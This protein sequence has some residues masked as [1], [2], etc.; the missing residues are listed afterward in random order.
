M[1]KYNQYSISK[2]KNLI[3]QGAEAANDY[4][5]I[6]DLLYSHDYTLSEFELV[7]IGFQNPNFVPGEVIVSNLYFLE[8]LM[9]TSKLKAFIKL[10][11]LNSLKRAAM[12]RL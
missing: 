6:Y 1:E 3:A 5:S 4:A 2:I 11:E 10:K 9:K 12:M 7:A 8:H